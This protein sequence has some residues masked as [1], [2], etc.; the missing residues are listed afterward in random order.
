MGFKAGQSEHVFNLVMIVKDGTLTQEKS[1][2]FT[3]NKSQ[4]VGLNNQEKRMTLFHWC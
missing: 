4:D 1:T 3:L 2:L